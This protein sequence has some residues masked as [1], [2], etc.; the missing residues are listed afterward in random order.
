MS[1]YLDLCF[2]LEKRKDM[3]LKVVWSWAYL[4]PLS[5]F[6]IFIRLIVHQHFPFQQQLLYEFD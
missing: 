5:G 4:S 1:H 6:Q 3:G 2:Y